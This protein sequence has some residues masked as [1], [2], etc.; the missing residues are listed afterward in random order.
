MLVLELLG[1]VLACVGTVALAGLATEYWFSKFRVMRRSVDAF[2][3]ARQ[4]WR[5]SR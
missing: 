2:K 3:R 4:G 1:I 5:I